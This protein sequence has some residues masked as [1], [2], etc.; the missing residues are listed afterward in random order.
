[1]HLKAAATRRISQLFRSVSNHSALC[2]H[3]SLLSCLA[4]SLLPLWQMSPLAPSSYTLPGASKWG[5][6]FRSV[7]RMLTGRVLR[8]DGRWS[9]ELSISILSVFLALASFSQTH[10]QLAA[11]RVSTT[12]LES[13]ELALQRSSHHA[14]STAGLPEFWHCQ[15]SDACSAAHGGLAVRRRTVPAQVLIKESSRREHVMSE[16]GRGSRP[17]SAANVMRPATRSGGERR[18]SMPSLASSP[19]SARLTEGTPSPREREAR[20]QLAER[21]RRRPPDPARALRAA[22]PG[23]GCGHGSAAAAE[24]PDQ[25]AG[26]AAAAEHGSQHA[27]ARAHAPAAPVG[28][29]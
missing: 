12:V 4:R 14:V 15:S 26:A 18:A 27:A 21:G 3:A 9:A 2:Q 25:D 24:G 29:A 22:A 1:M 6:Q 10:S 11:L 13:L 23:R 19:N 20:Q 28:P 8:E 5:I 17:G 7:M 16:Q